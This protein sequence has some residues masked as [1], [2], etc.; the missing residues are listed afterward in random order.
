[1]VNIRKTDQVEL[2]NL[3]EKYTLY[4]I[5]YN[6]SHSK[7]SFLERTKENESLYF[8]RS[9]KTEN[10]LDIY[11][12]CDEF[13]S[14]DNQ[15]YKFLNTELNYNID[16]VAKSSW[17][18]IQDSEFKMHWMHTHEHLESS[19]RTDLKTQWTFVHY[20]QIPSNMK[21]GDGNIIFKSEDKKLHTFIPE[22]NDIF[23]FS[24]ELPHL[25]MP[26]QSGAIDRVVY[27]SNLNLDFNCKTNP[28][29]RIRFDEI[30]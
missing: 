12:E 17:V 3:S 25:V 22:E 6:G 4:K 11:I 9:Y 28:N 18:Y 29:K 24:G 13:N 19:N 1:M 20:I 16:R 7:D 30:Y 15:V 5:K 23:I 26:S 21:E 10:S 8:Y 27:A 2:F 14:V